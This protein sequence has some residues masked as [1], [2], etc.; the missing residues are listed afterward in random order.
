V[1]ALLAAYKKGNET[2]DGSKNLIEI[3]KLKDQMA[4]EVV[5]RHLWMETIQ[6]L[7]NLFEK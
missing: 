2:A 1:D 5:E 6:T 4:I 3:I 7:L